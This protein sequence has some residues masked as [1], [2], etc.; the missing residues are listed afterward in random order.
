MNFTI[1]NKLN[2]IDQCDMIPL[3]KQQL[4][5][6]YADVFTGPIQSLPG[7]IHFELDSSVAPVQAP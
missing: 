3:I 6:S 2:K 7:E 4:V 1:P 5:N